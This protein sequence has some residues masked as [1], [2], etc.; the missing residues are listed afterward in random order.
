MKTTKLLFVSGLL[1]AGFAVHA[2]DIRWGVKAG[3]NF[4]NINAENTDADWGSRTGFHGGLLAHI[5]L[6]K[7][8]AIQPEVVYSMQGAKS[9]VAGEETQTINLNYLNVP[10][11]VQYMFNNGFRLQT[12]PQ[13]GFLMNANS[14]IG[15]GDHVTNTDLYNKTD[16]S[17]AFGAGYLSNIGLGVDARYNLGLTD[18]Y[19]PGG[20]KETNSVFQVGLFYMFAHRSK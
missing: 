5:H 14:K 7:T 10:V 8:W 2:Q 1:L 18:T 13:V 3:A 20:L 15:T 9:T 6:N 17:W 12:G 19:K 11:L 16:F 4:S